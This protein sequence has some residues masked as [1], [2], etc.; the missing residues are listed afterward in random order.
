MKQHLLLLLI[1]S[2][3]LS[4]VLSLTPNIDF[5]VGQVTIHVK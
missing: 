5:P 3:V 2:F 4:F 1:L